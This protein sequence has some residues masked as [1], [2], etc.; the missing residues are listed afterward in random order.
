[1][2][3]TPSASPKRPQDPTPHPGER[4]GPH[5]WIGLTVL[6]FAALLL[7]MDVTVLYMALP[8]LSAELEVGSSQMLWI[9]DVYPFM[10]A[11]FLVT[12]GTLG[13][14]IGRRRLLMI[15]A[16]AFSAASLLAAFSTSA[17][18]LIASRALLGIAGATVLPSTMSLISTMFKNPGQR[19]S[20][21]GMW[22]M[23][24][25][26]GAVIGPVVGGLMLERFWW[27]SVFLLGVP[28]MALLLLS[29][30]ALLP[31]H[32]NPAPGRLDPISVAL[33]LG[34]ILP[35]IHGLKEAAR[36]GLE[37]VPI[38]S[39]AIGC[40]L[41]WAFVH[42]QRRLADPL[43]DLRL[44]S[45]RA[46]SGALVVFLLGMITLHALT[47][48]FTQ[49]LQL[50]EGLSPVPAG[51]W[52][53]PY[54]S[55][56]FAGLGLAPLIARRV[57]PGYVIAGGLIVASLGFLLITQV[58]A[59]SGPTLLVIGSTVVTVGFGPLMVLG[60]NMIVGSAPPERAGAAASVSET[61]AELGAAL[62][63][64]VL[65]SVGTAVYRDRVA[66]TAGVPPEAVEAARDGLAAARTV[67]EHLPD[68]IA[69]PVLDAARAAFA[70]GISVVA[71][72][73]AGL[74]VVLAGMALTLLRHV[75]PIAESPITA[76]DPSS[77]G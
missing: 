59:V 65:G 35:V 5:A 13:D 50:V 14:R 46:F 72:I 77:V 47:L 3:S 17:E 67:T 66:G 69:A 75:R 73:S 10:L 45:A 20:A 39:M 43:L 55:G 23:A 21:I 1:M 36:T 9:A 44:F 34:A 19:A 29:A 25:S 56:T 54:V 31:E 42:R 48:F 61:G 7:A 53:I 8:R 11:G 24:F 2:T 26:V 62:G 33:S 22:M 12:M 70:D 74:L 60:T 38:V 41:A 58:D 32:R 4:A 40:A 18:M 71:A 51:L 52:M 27:G 37:T 28:V 6:A 30:P 76:A 57:R 16:A 49:Y 63:V 64:A 15:G 68:G